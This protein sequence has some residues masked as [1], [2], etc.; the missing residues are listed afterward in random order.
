MI[1]GEVR[2]TAEIRDAEPERLRTAEMAVRAA[3]DRIAD[4]GKAA[5]SSLALLDR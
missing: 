1:A 3:V 5:A 4:T 2:M